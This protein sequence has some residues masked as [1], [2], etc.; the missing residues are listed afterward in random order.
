EVLRDLGNG[1]GYGR[2]GSGG[3]AVGREAGPIEIHVLESAPRV[4]SRDG[5]SPR[6]EPPGGRFAILCRRGAWHFAAGELGDS[7]GRCER[8]SARRL[9]ARDGVRYRTRQRGDEQSGLEHDGDLYKLGRLGRL[10]RSCSAAA[11]R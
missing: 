9:T 2:R 8:A 10:L 4:S 5:R 7:L 3:V 6:G 11:D 1:A